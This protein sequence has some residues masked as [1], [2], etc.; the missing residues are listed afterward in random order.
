VRDEPRPPPLLAASFQTSPIGLTSMVRSS[1]GA[2]AIAMTFSANTPISFFKTDD[3]VIAEIS[4]RPHSNQFL[5][6]F[7]GSLK[8]MARANLGIRSPICRAQERF[9][10]AGHIH[11]V[12]P[13]TI[14]CSARRCCIW[15]E[16]LALKL[17]T[18]CLT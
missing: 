4:A 2:E 14:Q 16:K 5:Y 3:V 8:P 17:T 9:I 18:S 10:G 11:R 15:S 13:T 6:Y 12:P 7:A 1:A